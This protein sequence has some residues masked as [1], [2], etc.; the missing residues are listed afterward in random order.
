VNK[1]K[2]RGGRA[3]A[4]AE[5]TADQLIHSLLEVAHGLEGQFEGALQAV[6]LSRSKYWLLEQL[7][8]SGEPP[9]LSEL[10]AGQGC[11]PSNITQLV[12]RLE[13][14]GLVRRIDEPED[15]R[16]KRVEL[17]P[18][19]RDQQSAGSRQIARVRAEFLSSLSAADRK[20][21][22]RGLSAAK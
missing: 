14:D 22:A 17:T 5:P 18:L 2:P 20:A 9:M 1:T 15:R 8:N 7:A 19:G 13:A 4:S 12:D 3:T 16:S 10:A 11:A 6:G 21:L